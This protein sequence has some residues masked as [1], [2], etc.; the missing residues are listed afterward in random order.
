MQN[1]RNLTLERQ[2]FLDDFDSLP[3]TGQRQGAYLI[4]SLKLAKR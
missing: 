4:A 2:F 3:A 1:S